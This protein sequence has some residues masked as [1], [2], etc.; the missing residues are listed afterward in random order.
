MLKNLVKDILLK[1][2]M[3]AY[4]FFLRYNTSIIYLY[5]SFKT[6]LMNFIIID[7]S[8][9]ILSIAY[10]NYQPNDLG[11]LS[12]DDFSV[13][14]LAKKCQGGDEILAMLEQVL[15]DD[16]PD[17]I[18]ISHGPGFFNSIRMVAACAQS[19]ALAY[20]IPLFSFNSLL[21]HAKCQHLKNLS[22]LGKKHAKASNSAQATDIICLQQAIFNTDFKMDINHTQAI[23]KPHS[24]LT[25]QP[26]SY[27]Y[28]VFIDARMNEYYHARYQLR[29]PDTYQVTNSQNHNLCLK[30]PCLI[31]YDE[32]P[33][34]SH[35]SEKNNSEINIDFDV[36]NALLL[37]TIEQIQEAIDTSI[38]TNNAL[39]ITAQPPRKIIK[40]LQ[41]Q[42]L[43]N[44]L[45]FKE[46]D[47]VRNKVAANLEEQ[48]QIQALKK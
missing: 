38:N 7:Q 42:S 12:L 26:I 24:A 5:Q 29:V 23:S 4:I 27:I 6:Y 32:L 36:C 25:D 15:A 45:L 10:A 37:L 47:Y 46:L 30:A 20:D 21:M 2:S 28:D 16:P 14:N 11:M 8:T 40:T 41:N 44:H 22:A 17:A 13:Q 18:I 31:G 33:S 34:F 39:N 3:I 1:F 19:L 48:K 35:I 9:S 43:L